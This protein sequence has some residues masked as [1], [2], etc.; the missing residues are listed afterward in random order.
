MVAERAS[1]I[2]ENLEEGSVNAD[3]TWFVRHLSDR[4]KLYGLNYIRFAG[5]W[6][7]AAL[8]AGY[9]ASTTQSHIENGDAMVAYMTAVKAEFATL[10]ALSANTVLNRLN[11]IALKAEGSGELDAAIRANTK[12]GEALGLFEKKNAPIQINGDGNQIIIAA[13][14]SEAD[15]AVYQ[16]PAIQAALRRNGMEPPALSEPVQDAEVFD[17]SEG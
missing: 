2:E 3:S 12:I 16:D 13:P 6:K 1:Q 7:K 11:R 4:Q 5:D 17:V 9:S 14:R 15:D 10:Q 8:N